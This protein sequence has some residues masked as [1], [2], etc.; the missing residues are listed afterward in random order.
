MEEKRQGFKT[1]E[2]YFQYSNWIRIVYFSG[3]H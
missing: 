3:E 1:L 2:E